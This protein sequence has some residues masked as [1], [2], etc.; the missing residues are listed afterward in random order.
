MS[1]SYLQIMGARGTMPVPGQCFK[2]YGGNT[3]CIFLSIGG[4]HI[5]LDAGSG[6]LNIDSKFLGDNNKVHVL[7]SHTH[8]DHIIGLPAAGIMYDSTLEINIYGAKRNN[9]DI[10]EQLSCLMKPPLWPVGFDS[11]LADVTCHSL[12]SEFWL[13][14]VHISTLETNHPGGCTVF[15]LDYKDTSVVYATDIEIVSPYKEQFIDF[16]KNCTV[17]ICDGQ[18]SKEEYPDKIGFG[19]SSRDIV[20]EY[21]LESNCKQFLLFHHDPYSTDDILDNVQNELS[22][23][24]PKGLLAKEEMRVKL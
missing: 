9:L 8:I 24:T 10:K 11:F 18:Y 19:H 15:R 2:K 20:I 23:I 1:E 5:L 3:S 13:G 6:L 22:A 4:Q 17:L 16:A 12:Q 21:A 7:I 14:N